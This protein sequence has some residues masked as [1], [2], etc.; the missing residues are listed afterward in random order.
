M[1]RRR[2]AATNP[3]CA[4]IPLKPWFENQD[5]IRVHLPAGTEERLLRIIG[6]FEPLPEPARQARDDRPEA[7]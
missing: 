4:P 1:P 6:M 3:G 5:R 2:I 7:P